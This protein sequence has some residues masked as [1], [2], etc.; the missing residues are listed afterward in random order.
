L[1]QQGKT[2]NLLNLE[3]MVG[4]SILGK[5][6]YSLQYVTSVPEEILHL[7]VST[8]ALEK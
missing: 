3:E 6:P 8:A 2:C 4:K 5:M 1:G 7:R